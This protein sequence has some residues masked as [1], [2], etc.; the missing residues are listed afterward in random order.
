MTY[1]EVERRARPEYWKPYVL[2]QASRMSEHTKLSAPDGTKLRV[3]I[4]WAGRPGLDPDKE[5]SAQLERFICLTEI[6]GVQVYSLQKGQPNA[7]KAAGADAVI[8]D[9]DGRMNDWV[10]TAH[11]MRRLDLVVSV[12]TSPL[13]LAGALGIPTIGLCQYARC[14][15]WLRDRTDTPWYPSMELIT[16]PTRWDWTTPLQQ[17][18]EKIERMVEER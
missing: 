3:G 7:L 15:R 1:D 9:L 6:P 14:W 4:V 10:D 17:V 8:I 18:M 12:D 2:P 13:H 16:Q 11:L 5:R